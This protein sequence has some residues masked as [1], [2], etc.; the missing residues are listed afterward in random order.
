LHPVQ[1]PQANWKLWVT[2]APPV[3]IGP[4]HDWCLWQSRQLQ[5]ALHVPQLG[6]PQSVPSVL[7]TQVVVSVSVVITELHAPEPQVGVV[8]VRVRVPVLPQAV[9]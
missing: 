9:A 2:Q 4:V 6:G 1:P 8:T 7:R 3:H 5:P